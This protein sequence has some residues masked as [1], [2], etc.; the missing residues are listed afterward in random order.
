MAKAEAVNPKATTQ[1]EAVNPKATTQA[2]AQ[3]RAEVPAQVVLVLAAP[4]LLAYPTSLPLRLRLPH[5]HNRPP[6]SPTRLWLQEEPF[7]EWSWDPFIFI[8]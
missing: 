8:E 5:R 6:M 4:L 1:A 7:G 3:A 2:Q